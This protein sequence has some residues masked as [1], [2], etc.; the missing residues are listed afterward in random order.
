M[1]KAMWIAVLPLLCTAGCIRIDTGVRTHEDG[2]RLEVA[3]ANGDVNQAIRQLIAD[4]GWTN[5]GEGARNGSFSSFHTG[6]GSVTETEEVPPGVHRASYSESWINARDNDGRVVHFNV[7]HTNDRR[8]TVQV[9]IEGGSRAACRE[10][11][12]D[13]TRRLHPHANVGRDHSPLT[14]CLDSFTPKASEPNSYE[15]HWTAPV[16]RSYPGDFVSFE[17][18]DYDGGTRHCTIHLDD[19]APWRAL[20][21]DAAK[22]SVHI[23]WER[24]AGVLILEGDRAGATASGMATFAP[25]AAYVDEMAKLVSTKLGIDQRLTLFFD[26]V[27]LDYARQI[28]RAIGDELT[29]HGLLTLSHY[30]VSP[31]FI[32]GSREAGYAL[33]VEEIVRLTNYHIPLETLRGFKKAGYDFSVEQL[34]RIRN[35]HL[36]IEDF[37]GFRAAGY[38]LSIDE[39]IR[40]KNYHVPVEWVRALRDAGYRYNLDEIIKLRNYHVSPEEIVG[41]DRAGYKLSIDEIIKAKNYHLDADNAARLRQAGYSFTLDELI[42]LQNYHVPTDFIAQLH[43]AD[44]ENFTADELIDFHQKHFSADTINKIRTAKRHAQP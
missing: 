35:Y 29:L 18:R 31:E 38:D 40:A 10:V 17:W 9:S 16:D 2:G 14:I 34:I 44:Y 27:D 32:R 23:R 28:Q 41:W 8:A 26:P 36:E 15:A 42:K 7:R 20:D 22:G 30:H 1:K 12:A 24:P 33:S 3:G 13:L 25:T 43:N 5:I 4:R 6:P 11:A 19:P 39:M 37:T 21:Q